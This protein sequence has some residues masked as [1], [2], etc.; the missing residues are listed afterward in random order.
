MKSI[1]HFCSIILEE[2][3][4]LDILVNNA[5]VALTEKV[6]TED[7]FEMHVAVNHLGPFLLTN[8]LLG[9]LFR[10]FISFL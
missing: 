8:I 5:G 4:R 10:F 3:T 9:N 6:L 2:E 1:R 7:G